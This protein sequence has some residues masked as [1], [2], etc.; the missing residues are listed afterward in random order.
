MTKQEQSERF[1]IKFE[2]SVVLSREEYKRLLDNTIRVDM[3]Y[4]DHELAKTR[5]VEVEE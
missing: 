4:L 5:K 2:D 3:E 1:S